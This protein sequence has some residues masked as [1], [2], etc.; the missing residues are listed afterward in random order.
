[1]STDVRVTP[2]IAVIGDP[3]DCLTALRSAPEAL[4]FDGEHDVTCGH[5]AVVIGVDITQLRNRRQLRI[6]LRDIELQCVTLA[7]RLRRL[8]HVVL[9]VS[10]SPVAAEE[11]LLRTCDAVARRIHSRL[12]Q[13]YARSIVITAVLIGRCDDGARLAERLTA[14]VRQRECLDGG[15]ALRWTDIARTPIGDVGTNA[16]L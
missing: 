9:A 2:P 15:I 16:Y 4:A 1:M 8:E 10:D 6:V 14:R 5:R 3:L 11:S 12:E 13:A 7:G